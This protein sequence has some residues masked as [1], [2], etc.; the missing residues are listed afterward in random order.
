MKQRFEQSTDLKS[1]LEMVERLRCSPDWTA[2]DL[3]VEMI[4]THI[5][6][7]LLGKSRVLKLKKPVDFGFLDYT[8][9]EK[10]RLACE[11][12]VSLNRRLCP[13][14]Y[15]GVQAIRDAAGQ[16]VLSGEG[17]IIDYAVLM[18][19]L[20]ADR[21]L[22]RM[23]ARDEVTEADIDRVAHRLSDFHK[24]AR[25][26]PEVDH[27]GSP[28]VIRTNWEEN[29]TQTRPY[30]DR[31]IT[32]QEFDTIYEWVKR[33]MEASDELLNKR[34]RDGRICDGHGDVRSESVSVT[35]GI[36]IFDCIEFNERF[37]Y[38]DVASEA[39]FLAMDL[40]ARGR[41]DLGYYFAE[42]YMTR[43]GDP[44]IFDLL[45]FYRCYRAY[46]RGKVLSFRLDEKEF[47]TS[48]H[49]A[50]ATRAKSY[51]HLAR[52]YATPLERPTVIIVAGLSGTGKT[53]IA[54]AIAGELG[55]KVVSADA[56]R[57]SLFEFR[58]RP[59]AY[60]EG[61]YS[62]EGNRLT[63]NKL[64]ER[65]KALLAEGRGVILDATFRRASDRR[66]V[67]EVAIQSGA[68]FKIIEC[69]LSPPLVRSRIERRASREEGLSDATWE[70]Y[71]NQNK[72][73]EAISDRLA[74]VHLALD[75]S[76]AM[77]LT[78]HRATDWLREKAGG[79]VY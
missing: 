25:R 49:A 43:S 26:G 40:E 3:P 24:D 33:W 5:S 37:R 42:R 53:S 36:C 20:P 62:K 54:R 52:R 46:V 17:P 14:A 9:I 64:V 1:W 69:K 2:Q 71:L 6:V 4:Q 30:I 75:T 39:A 29:F 76:G 28:K 56:V 11:A 34:V 13:D 51:F 55:L 78:S 67:E 48:E 58:D 7:V 45:P 41:P 32:R 50:A 31:T 68:D 10:R 79:S 16:P 57:K 22:D 65:E 73:F 74:D 21:F 15:L 70:T 47:T 61:P 60:G 44:E 19:R 72:E 35:D 8:T 12:E 59:Y 66:M 63:Y 27:Y 38:C 77:S 23:V 18:K